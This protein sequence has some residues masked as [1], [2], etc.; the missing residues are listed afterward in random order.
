M[1]Q[2]EGD[3]KYY[4]IYVMFFILF[5][6]IL[7]SL[8]FDMS[9]DLATSSDAPSLGL[10]RFGTFDYTDISSISSIELYLDTIGTFEDGYD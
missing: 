6:I 9:R 2:F 1:L 5:P 3:P 4:L 7:M 10:L 8:Y